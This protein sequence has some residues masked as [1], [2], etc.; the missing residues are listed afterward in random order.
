[1]NKICIMFR[2]EAATDA[3]FQRMLFDK[4][5]VSSDTLRW[6]SG[7]WRRCRRWG[8]K[9]V[10]HRGSESCVFFSSVSFNFFTPTPAVITNLIPRRISVL[11]HGWHHSVT[12]ARLPRRMRSECGEVMIF[13]AEPCTCQ[14]WW[15]VLATAQD[16]GYSVAMLQ[17]ASQF[18]SQTCFLFYRVLVFMLFQTCSVEHKKSLSYHSLSFNF[19]FSHTLWVN[20]DWDNIVLGCFAEETTWGWTTSF[21]YKKLLLKG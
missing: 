19:Y 12:V 6:R 8:P 1:M 15:H 18:L 14:S 5:H 11:A 3:C 20:G 16:C 17:R 4:M 7:R 2:I 9:S 13:P 10:W 21:Q